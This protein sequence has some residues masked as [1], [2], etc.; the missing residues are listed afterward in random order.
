MQK[1]GFNYGYLM[2]GAGRPAHWHPTLLA[3]IRLNRRRR[4]ACDLSSL[5]GRWGL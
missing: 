2:A 4:K 5:K 1:A 3:R